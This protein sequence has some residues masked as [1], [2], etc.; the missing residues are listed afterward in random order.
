MRIQ[1]AGRVIPPA[2]GSRILQAGIRRMNGRRLMVSGTSSVQTDIWITASTA[3][4]TGWAQMAHGSR[5]IRVATGCVIPLAGGMLTNMAGIRR[6]R[7]YGLMECAT[8]SE[9]TVT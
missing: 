7:A 1:E 8:A 4:V 2:G 3:M 6:V 5:F 9:Q